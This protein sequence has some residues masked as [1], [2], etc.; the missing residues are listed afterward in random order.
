MPSLIAVVTSDLAQI[1]RAPSMIDVGCINTS[2][3]IRTGV[4]SSLVLVVFFFLL[5]PIFL[6][7]NL[8]I[9]G[10]QGTGGFI[11]GL[12]LIRGLVPRILGGRGLRFDRGGVRGTVTPWATLIHVSDVRRGL[13]TGLCL[14]INCFFYQLLPVIV[15]PT[16]LLHLC[17]N[18]RLEPLSE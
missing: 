17:L 1:L 13:E 12:V 8:T 5:L 9:L 2:G 18:W 7:K 10:P 6:V 16:T 14:G 15:L 11:G 4:F 3:G